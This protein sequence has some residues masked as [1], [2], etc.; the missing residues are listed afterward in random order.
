MCVCPAGSGQLTV[1]GD[2]DLL[3]VLGWAEP[4]TG[5]VSVCIRGRERERCKAASV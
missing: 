3:G 2:C 1:P 5:V 4:S